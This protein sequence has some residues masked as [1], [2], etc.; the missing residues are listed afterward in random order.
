MR[1]PRC[2]AKQD[3]KAPADPRWRRRVATSFLLGAVLAGP[4]TAQLGGSLTLSSQA[5]LR[6]Q[7]IGDHRPVAE[8]ELVH[9]AAGGFYIGGSA[10]LV[11]TRDEGVKPLS[12]RQYAGFARHL[13]PA[14]A[15]DVG[16]VHSGYT[17]YSGIAGGGSYTEA[18]VGMTGRHLSGRLY[19]SPGYFRKD[20]PTLYAELNG[21][22]DLAPD[23]SLVAHAGRLTH[24][25]AHADRGDRDATDW[26]IGLRRHLGPVDLDAAWTGHAQDRAAYGAGDRSD[27]AL[28]I[29]LSCA[30]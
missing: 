9:D 14:T 27:G 20:E 26:R 5:R 1:S 19:F 11:A 22:L 3:A 30:F 8:L 12:F 7:P 15:I 23:W 24:L 25:K 10:T 28:V 18:Y 21:D 13:S 29:A 16:M 2:R 17:S 4:A 6:G